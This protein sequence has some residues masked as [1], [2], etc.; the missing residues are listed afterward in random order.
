MADDTDKLALLHIE[1]D[2]LEDGVGT[3]GSGIDLTEPFKAQER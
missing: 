2:V 1:V 3:T